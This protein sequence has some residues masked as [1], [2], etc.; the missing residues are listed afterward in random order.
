MLLP[1]P[2]SLPPCC[3]T[4]PSAE[5][6]ALVPWPGPEDPAALADGSLVVAAT[7][8]APGVVVVRAIGEIDLLTAPGWRRVLV[9][10]IRIASPASEAVAPLPGSGTRSL[11]VCDLSPVTFLGASGLDVLVELDELGTRHGID[12]RVVAASRHVRRVLQLTGLDRR[13]RVEPRLERAVAPT[14]AS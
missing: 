10:A 1:P 3:A 11:L 2:N 7:T 9:G 13:F 4:G 6:G 5:H 12:L 14:P 8:P